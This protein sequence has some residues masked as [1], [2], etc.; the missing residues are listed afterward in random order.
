M[1]ASDGSADP[2]E[3]R[4]GPRA[5][6]RF[7]LAAPVFAAAGHPGMRTPSMRDASWA[8]VK[9][10]VLRAEALGYDATWFSDHLFHGRQG[11]FHESWTALSMAAGFTTRIRLVNNHLGIGLRDPRVVA[12][13]ATTLA[14]ATRGR[15]ELFFATGYREREYRAYG[16]PWPRQSERDERLAEAIDVVRQL[17]SGEPAWSDRQY[18]PVDGAIAAPTAAEPPLV[19]VGGPLDDRTLSTIAT[20]ADGWN[21]FPLD[22]ASYRE[23]A[24]RVDAACA[25]VGRAPGSLRRSLEM[26]VLVL[27]SES[28]WQRWLESWERLRADAPLDDA[29]SDMLA[30]DARYDAAATNAM[31]DQFIIG[32]AE[33]V[34]ERVEAYRAAGVT[35]LVCWFMDLPSH[36]SLERVAEMWNLPAGIDD[37]TAYVSSDTQT[38]TNDIAEEHS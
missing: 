1:T 23:A 2:A 11:A 28:E 33:E 32:T 13:M 14:D 18:Y 27:D 26:Q 38:S 4:T 31:R 9:D 8:T 36:R 29:T 21:S 5:P 35:D 22:L 16:L 24:A 7:A 34:R 3:L 17:W 37:K 25:S 20:R 19:W 12:K 6:M 30:P 15:F 10:A